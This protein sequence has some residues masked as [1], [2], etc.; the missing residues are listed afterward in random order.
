VRKISEGLPDATGSI[1]AAMAALLEEL[2]K[3]KALVRKKAVTG[4]DTAEARRRQAGV[5]K[6]IAEL[7]TAAAAEADAEQ[8]AI[9]EKVADTAAMVAEAAVRTIDDRMLLLSIP[10]T[11]EKP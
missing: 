4:E 9:A 6:R 1:A 2:E 8:R 7:R 3:L 10:P 11:P 5:E